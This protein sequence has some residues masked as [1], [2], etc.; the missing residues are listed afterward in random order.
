[1]VLAQ[2]LSY[3]P[4][5]MRASIEARIADIAQ[6]EAG[7]VYS[8]TEVQARIEELLSAGAVT[9]AAKFIAVEENLQTR[10]KV[11]GREL[12]RL[13]AALRMHLL[14]GDWAA[15]QNTQV[16]SDL[17]VPERDGARDTITFFAAL[18]ELRKPDGDW[19]GVVQTFERLHTRRLDIIPYA[20]NLF[21][22]RIS[23]LLRGNCFSCWRGRKRIA[24]IRR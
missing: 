20:V 11:P 2:L 9:A 22:V 5:A 8:L 13:R 14:R 23:V 19:E 17:S 16:P 24:R 10:G 4:Y 12:A 15:I 6:E 3:A 21:A 1:M 18:A 7:E